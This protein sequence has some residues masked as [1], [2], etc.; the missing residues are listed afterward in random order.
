[1][2]RRHFLAIALSALLGFALL[3]GRYWWVM[4][5]ALIRLKLMKAPVN[6]L[7]NADFS[8]ATNVNLPDYWGTADRGRFAD[9]ADLFHLENASPVKNARA[10]RVRNPEAGVTLTLQS[11]AT[12]VARPVPY[13]FSIYL[14]SDGEDFAAALSLGWGGNEAIKVS[15]SWQRYSLTYQPGVEGELRQGF[16]ARIVLPQQG[17]LWLAAPQLEEGEAATTF[18]TALMDDHPL[19]VYPQPQADELTFIQ[20]PDLPAGAA[21]QGT[22]EGIHINHQKRQLM[23]DGKAFMVFGIALFEPKEW[24]LREIAGLGFNSVALT[25]DPL[26]QGSEAKSSVEQLLAQLDA[27]QQNGLRVLPILRHRPESPLRQM[28]DEKIAFIMAC[29]H[30]PAILGWWALDEP[31]QHLAFNFESDGVELYREVKAADPNHPVL[32]NENTWRAG[33]WAKHFLQSTD[34]VSMDLYP[35]GRYENPLAVIGE[36][37]SQMNSECLPLHKPTAFWLQLYGHFDA[38]REPTPDELRAMTYLVF[39]KGVRLI[40]YWVYKPMNQLLWQSLKPLLEEIKKLSDMVVRDEARWH[41]TGTTQL[42]VHYSFWQ[43][44]DRFYLI[45]CNS[46]SE[47]VETKFELEQIAGRSFGNY[48]SWSADDRKFFAGERLY[49]NFAPYEPQVVELW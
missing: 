1:M 30:H 13:T 4:R 7:R 44:G 49:I 9:V 28:I 12:F 3:A 25:F 29:K 22:G 42:Q 39:I 11:C 34:I 40:F 48:R 10:L 15:H 5:R 38:P 18:A 32:I 23:T 16:Q 45:A 37:L 26:K 14:R 35:V 36:R 19:P 31:T 24:Q 41:S 17:N 20:E 43:A 47:A 27:A 46:G 33:D 21:S 2:K 6:L 8:Q